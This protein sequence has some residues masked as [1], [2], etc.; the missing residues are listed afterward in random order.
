MTLVHN[1]VDHVQIERVGK[2]YAGVQNV[3][4]LDEIELTI[5]RS[6]VRADVGETAAPN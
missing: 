1:A 6:S 3:H 5:R 2:S 4:V